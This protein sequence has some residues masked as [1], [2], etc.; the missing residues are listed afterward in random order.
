MQFWNRL[1]SILT[2]GILISESI[3]IMAVNANIYN[4]IK[5]I[6][7]NFFDFV[8]MVIAILINIINCGF[9]LRYSVCSD[10]GLSGLIVRFYTWYM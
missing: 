6:Y 7:T 3:Q 5:L 4:R 1:G 2:Q 9:T 10:V 8:N